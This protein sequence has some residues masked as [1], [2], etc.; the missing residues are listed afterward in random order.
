MKIIFV[1]I[2]LALASCQAAADLGGDWEL[3]SLNGETVPDD[4]EI[5]LSV[6][7]GAVSGRAACNGYMGSLV[8][9]GTKVT[10]GRLGSTKMMCPPPLME[11]ER[12]FLGAMREVS[13]AASGPD[14]LTLSDESGDT[15]L[16]F[17]L[18]ASP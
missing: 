18:S 10:M 9:E 1:A 14:S 7:E 13:R 8:Q 17:V 11:W 4:I 2:A 3:V 16:V 12:R 15:V 6:A 5:T